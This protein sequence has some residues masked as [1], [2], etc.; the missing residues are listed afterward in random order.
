MILTNYNNYQRK[1]NLCF[2]I[3]DKDWGLQPNTLL[4]KVTLFENIFI[5]G[6]QNFVLLLSF[7]MIV[8]TMSPFIKINPIVNRLTDPIIKISKNIIDF[9]NNNYQVAFTSIFLTYIMTVSAAF[10]KELE[11]NKKYKIFNLRI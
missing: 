2:L 11:Q 6:T 9:D 8:K 10:G 3:P 5:E 7:L 1:K 4:P